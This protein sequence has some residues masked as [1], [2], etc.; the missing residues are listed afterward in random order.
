[1]M[2]CRVQVIAAINQTVEKEGRP[3]AQYA[4]GTQVWLEG[5]NL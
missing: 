1:M 2:E 5:K 3:E 4:M